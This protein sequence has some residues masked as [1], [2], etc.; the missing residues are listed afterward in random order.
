MIKQEE[1]KKEK[2]ATKCGFLAAVNLALLTGNYSVFCDRYQNLNP[3][4]LIVSI[5][6]EF[7]IAILFPICS[8]IASIIEK[9]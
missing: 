2:S 3:S 5:N 6:V 1:R 4:N 8:I 7:P 9:Q